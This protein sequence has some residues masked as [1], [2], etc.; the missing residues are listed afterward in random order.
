MV[1]SV[2]VKIDESVKSVGVIGSRSITFTVAPKVGDIVQDL[3]GRHY[4]IATGGAV[5]PFDTSSVAKA[6]ADTQGPF[7]STS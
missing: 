2:H 7:R 6:M 1:K 4:H 5:R 3:L